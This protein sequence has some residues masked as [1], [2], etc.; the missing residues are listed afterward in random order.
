MALTYKERL[1]FLE[2]LKKT[3]IDLAVADRM[4]L[5]AHDRTLMRPTLLSLVKELTNLDAYISV[6]HGIL[7]QD[8][9]DEV[10]SDYD[11]PIEGSHANLREKIKMFLFAYENLSDAIHDFNID[12]V[13]KAFEVS[14]LSRT[15]NV[16]FLL[17]KLCCR[18]PQAVFGFLFKLARKNPTVY[19]PYLSSLIVR[20][21]VDGELKSTY[22]RD[23]ISY[24][25]SLSRAHSILSVAACQCLLYIACFRREVAVAARDI[26]EWVFDSG[27]A[28]YMNRNVVEMFCELFGYEC[29]VFS[30]YDNDCLY[31]FPFD[32][33]ILEKIG[34]GIHEFYI[35]FDR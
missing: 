16:Q 9:W 28:R 24:V 12:E 1:E 26:I 32:L 17:F 19:L 25:K 22:I 11:T 10:I 3:P 31:F 23:Y 8:E 27:I 18:N 14:L 21:K 13:L 34:E 2:S 29:K 6:M 15:R 4:V 20:C 30:S 5:Y 7:T 35:H 33:P